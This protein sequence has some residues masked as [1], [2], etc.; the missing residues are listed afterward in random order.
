MSSSRIHRFY[1]FDPEDRVVIEVG[2]MPHHDEAA[3]GD[4]FGL[5][6]EVDPEVA[7]REQ[8]V[9]II[10]AANDEAAQIINDAKA[11]GIAEQAA[12]RREAKSE[13]AVLLEQ[14]RNDG[15]QEGMTTA[16]REGDAI[17]AQAR[18]VLAEAEAE[19]QHMRETFEPQMVDL[20]VR[21]AEKLIGNAVT[22]NPAVI[23]SLVRIGMD[24]ATITGDVKV[25]VSP[26]DYEMA[27]SRKDDITALTDGS[28][29]VEIVKDPSLGKMDCIIETPFGNIDCSLGHQLESLCHNITYL[30]N[31]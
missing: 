29:R 20:L 17:R 9:L 19:Y 15:Y 4:E 30:L 28:V 1:N 24:N 25:Y 13:A 31:G 23:L 12:L 26:D 21:I 6:E 27:V 8:A 10:Q 11:A 16:T 2:E 18:Q 14:S 22:L 3:L 5:D 7:A